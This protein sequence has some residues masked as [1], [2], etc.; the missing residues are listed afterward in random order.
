MS[1]RHS[2]TILH[3]AAPAAFG[4]LESVLLEL[5][6]GH[7]RAGHRVVL[8]AV[9]DPGAVVGAV[10]DRA[11]AAGV[12]VVPLSVPPRAYPLEYRQLREVIRRIRPDV[13]HTHGARSDLIG[14]LAARRA[15]VPWI[16]TMHGF[17]GGDRKNR[18]YEWLQ[19]RACRRAQAVV[20]V[21]SP[22]RNV[23]VRGGVSA[24]RVH[25]LANAWTP[26]PLLPRGEARR[27][28]GVAEGE[29]VIGWVGRLTHE[30]GA[31][32]FLEALALIQDVPWRADLIGEGRER[33]VL[34]AQARR[35]EIGHRVHWHG[36]LPEAASLFPAFDSWVL[37]SRT[38]GTPIA[39]FEAMA[40]RVPVIVADVGGVPDVVSSVEAL[41]VPAGRPEALAAALRA[42]L[43]APEAAAARAA[44]AHRRLTATYAPQPWLDAHETLYFR[45][46]SGSAARA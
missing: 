45:L 36:L 35:L 34:E 44:A 9:L 42:A 40:A 20:A 11:A 16:S 25:L 43:A 33:A 18:F 26:Q 4:G 15:G 29:P 10:P 28:L 6:G 5:T 3:V 19:V 14:G 37:S 7:R 22:I 17:T 27:R 21:S 2:L 23:L 8:A 46:R 31:D 13:V 38:E 30:K 39:L 12:E 24:D 41:L 32:L 1:S